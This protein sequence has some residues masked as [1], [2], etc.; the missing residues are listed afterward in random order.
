MPGL[1]EAYRDGEG[2]GSGCL[3]YSCVYLTFIFRSF[4]VISPYI[5]RILRKIYGDYTIYEWT[6]IGEYTDDTRY[7]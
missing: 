3:V 4:S 2:V 6:I 1:R 5:I 7:H